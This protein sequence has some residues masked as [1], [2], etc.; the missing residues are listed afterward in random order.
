MLI[1]K[2]VEDIAEVDT[3]KEPV[4]KEDD[5]YQT[6]FDKMKTCEETGITRQYAFVLMMLKSMLRG[7]EKLEKTMLSAMRDDLRSDEALSYLM[8]LHPFKQELNGAIEN[9]RKWY[10]SPNQG[11]NQFAR[12]FR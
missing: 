12:I 6:V 11:E 1:D 9:L 10:K 7:S 5:S 3:A 8:S 2:K 4:P